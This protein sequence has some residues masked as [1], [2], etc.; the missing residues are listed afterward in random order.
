[1]RARFTE[2]IHREIAH[3]RGGRPSGIVAKMNQL[4]D[5]SMIRELYGASRAGV[6]INLLVR[7][8]CCLRPGVPG[9]S[10]TVRVSSVVGRFLEHS[11]VYRFENG[12]TPEFYV[13]SADWMARNLDSRVETVVA[14]TDPALQH[15]LDA[16]LE[17]YERDNCSAWDCRAD[18]TYE[19]RV[20]APGEPARAV[21]E[22]F[23]ASVRKRKTGE[24]SVSG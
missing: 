21:Q 9:L 12:G 2:L 18:G 11:R 22:V 10:E 23:I 3:A 20:P 8:L 14:V 5:A 1:M 24:T 6:P 15:E 13:G 4:Q 7:G 16:M 19:R 17:V